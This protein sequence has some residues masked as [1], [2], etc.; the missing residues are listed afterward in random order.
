MGNG[1]EG[2]KR[3]QLNEHLILQPVIHIAE[4]A[5]T[6]KGR[7]RALI[8]AGQLGE[9]AIWGEGEY[10]NEYIKQSHY[11]DRPLADQTV[12]FVAVRKS[13][14]LFLRSLD[15]KAWEAVG[16]ANNKRISVRALAYIMAGHVRHHVA[17]L[18]ERYSVGSGK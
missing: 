1:R 11:D 6:A 3:G 13:N 2:L 18:H 7:W 12:E 14:V 9:S 17:I 10:E 5:R 16:T 4:D 8:M 15:D